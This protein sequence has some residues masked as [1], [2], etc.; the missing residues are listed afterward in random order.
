MAVL[1]QLPGMDDETDREAAFGE[2]DITA[3]ISPPSSLLLYLLTLPYLRH[4]E[5]TQI[6]DKLN[7]VVGHPKFVTK[8]V[9]CY[10]GS[11]CISMQWGALR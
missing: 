2:E 3:R 5:H 9:M 11:S 1:Y 7:F 8:L 6:H 4:T 10:V